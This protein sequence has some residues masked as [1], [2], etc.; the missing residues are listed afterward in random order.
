[1]GGS[2]AVRNVEVE[3]G[4]GGEIAKR[5]WFSCPIPETV[6]VVCDVVSVWPR[7]RQEHRANRLMRNIC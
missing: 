5:M 3:C 6:P 2:L 1:M 7:D 4:C